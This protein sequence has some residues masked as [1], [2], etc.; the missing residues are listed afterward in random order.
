MGQFNVLGRY[1]LHFHQTGENSDSYFTDNSVYKSQ[2]RCYVIHGTNSTQILRNV[3]FNV[4]GSCFYLEDGNEEKNIL[5][6]PTSNSAQVSSTSN[7][8]SSAQLTSAHVSSGQV[9]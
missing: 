9:N 4:K 1:P 7:Q 2:F 6:C 3:A 8:S 5:M